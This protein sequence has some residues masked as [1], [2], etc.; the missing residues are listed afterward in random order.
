M[1]GGKEEP[2]D[3][4]A[5][6]SLGHVSSGSK[7]LSGGCLGM[8]KESWGSTHKLLS[9]RTLIRGRQGPAG[10]RQGR[11]SLAHLWWQGCWDKCAPS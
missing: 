11:E 8:G 2:G 4:E 9:A 5:T 1:E 7:P 6:L 10:S 3:T